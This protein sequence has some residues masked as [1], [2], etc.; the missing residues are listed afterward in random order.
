MRKS[1]FGLFFVGGAV[2]VVGLVGAVLVVPSFID[3]NQYKGELTA[4]VRTYLGRDL[5]I[6]GDIEISVLPAPA[7]IATDVSLANAEGAS[8]AEMVRLKSL[9]VRI[10]PAPLLG[11][12]IQVETVKLVEPVIELE[13][14]AD[15]RKNWVFAATEEENVSAAAGQAAPATDDGAPSAA[16]EPPIRLDS[17]VIENGTIIYRDST[18]GT[19]EQID[20][21]NARVAAASLSGPFES[22]GRLSVRGI[23]LGYELSVGK[24][25]HGRTVPLGLTV[26]LAPGATRIE[27]TGALVSLADTPKFKGKIKA[28]G[29]SLAGLAHFGASDGTLPGFLAQEF[30]VD[31]TVV[32]SAGKAG[33]KDLSLRL[34]DAQA[35]G[36]LSVALAEA[37]TVSGE[38]AVNHINLDEWLS[39]PTSVAAEAITEA[40]QTATG[41]EGRTSLPLTA[42]KPPP[43]APDKDR[44]PGFAL[45]TDVNGFL[46]V[47]V[48]AVTFRNLMIRQVR[49]GAEMAGGEITV[50]QLSGQF[51]GS[52]E[53]A[54][55]GFVTSTEGRPKFEGEVEASVSDL[56]RVL[57]WLGVAAPKVPSDRLRK[58]TLTSNLSITP[59]EAQ[60]FGLDLKLD[61][62]RLTGGITVALRKRL[63]FGADLT[64]DRLNLDAYLRNAGTGGTKTEEPDPATTAGEGATKTEEPPPESGTPGVLALWS[65]LNSFDANLVARVK[66][67]T[68]RATP[69]KEV[70]FDGTLFNSTLEITRASVKNAAGA[71][72][73]VNGAITGLDG[74][75][76]L[77][78]LWFD[79]GAGNLSRLFRLL[80]VES[81]VDTNLLGKVSVKGQIEG[82]LLKPGI[83]AL[84]KATN[85]EVGLD[86]DISLLPPRP[87]IDMKVKV[88]NA[89]LARFLRALKINYRPRGR[90][91][92]LDI[93]ARLTGDATALTFNDIKGTVDAVPVKGH[94]VLGL[95]GPRP[96]ISASL[97]TGE[98]VIQKY[99]P[100]QR[101]SWLP[102]DPARSHGGARV[103]PAAWMPPPVDGGTGPGILPV[104]AG[105]GRWS[106]D[107]IDLSALRAFDADLELKAAGI[108]YDKIK[109]ENADI[110][111]TVADGVLR[112]KRVAGRLFGGALSG[113]VVVRGTR[114]PGME[115][116]LVL[117]DGDLARALL[118]LTGKAV[119]TGTMG[120]NLKLST[121]GAS[122]AD[123]VAALGGNGSLAL[124]RIGVEGKSRGTS[125]AAALDLITGLNKLSGLLG[126]GKGKGLADIVGT[127]VVENGIA[128]SPDL[129]LVSALGN[130]DAKGSV[131]LVKWL[132]DMDGEVRLVETLATK[133][134][135]QVTGARTNR[136]LPFEIRG[137]LDAPNVKLKTAALQS[138]GGKPPEPAKTEEPGAPEDPAESTEPPPTID[139][140]LK[141][142]KTR[143]RL[144]KDLLKKL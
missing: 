33:F 18:S 45:P 72:A 46:N 16:S 25:I 53:V 11:G 80:G 7:L 84:L 35:T 122:V 101:T 103:I 59:K 124:R 23:P 113:T 39:F 75:P 135:S 131:D 49:A 19:V 1:F 125:L 26:M 9:E 55:Y 81:P 83:K 112:A 8:A 4:Q 115:T 57:T 102:S 15:G 114:T 92:G 85:I 56:R 109:L 62:S 21:V 42:G 144:L 105:G 36:T 129:R 60:I 24:V 136:T 77:K 47:F 82:S 90:I 120:V 63:S 95:V 140:I 99:L 107:P 51:P 48:D 116:D 94:A 17:F 91:G 96:H 3:W 133:L 71:S 20:E 32:A 70:A 74:I 68:Y 37:T 134:L 10:S 87:S 142:K 108:V 78:A 141:D 58:L 34:G 28:S 40:V 73:N 139:Q 79:L 132:I 44:Q 118:A 52:S 126:G 110:A 43:K 67:V 54:I 38:I 100:M 65:I 12:N 127:F 50:S 31:G 130:G 143:Q 69:I 123:M 6:H 14:L 29:K 5:V 111:A 30:R 61:S 137:P 2:L 66:S 93:A 41:G 27:A 13:V 86:G 22:S 138:G 117:R 89:D 88:K 106:G 97:D 98:V 104:A 128:R 76:K 121:E 64:L 119:A